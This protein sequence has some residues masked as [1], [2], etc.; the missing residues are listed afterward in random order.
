M[1]QSQKVFL[2]LSITS[3]V[4]QL[5]LVLKALLNLVIFYPQSQKL[6]DYSNS[7][8]S[9]MLSNIYTSYKISLREDDDDMSKCKH[10]SSSQ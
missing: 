5:T 9:G 7:C 6:S 3:T 2:S 8:Q 10:R 4:S 1:T